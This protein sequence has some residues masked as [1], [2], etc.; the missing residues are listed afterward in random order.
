MNRIAMTTAASA[1]R[2]SR[3]YW[4]A[5]IGLASLVGAMAP[6]AHALEHFHV[7]L[8]KT[9]VIRCP[10]DAA[11]S[12]EL[13]GIAVTRPDRPGSARRA[14]VVND[15]EARQKGSSSVIEIDIGATLDI[16]VRGGLP[17]PGPVYPMKLEEMTL[18][19]DGR[20]AIATTAFDRHDADSPR[21]DGFNMLAGW[22]LMDGT[23]REFGIVM[24]DPGE[25]HKASVRR[26]LGATLDR[27]A[28][29]ALAY[30][31][32]EGLA[33]LPG[34]RLLFGIRAI[35]QDHQHATY[36]TILIE[37]RYLERNG[38]LLLDGTSP[39]HVV[40]DIGNALREA[41]NADIGLSGL[42]YHAAQNRLYMLTS[43][44]VQR[45]GKLALDAYLW[46]IGFDQ[47]G[48]LDPASL[49]L[50]NNRHNATFRFHHKAEGI[51]FLD[52]ETMVVVH[53]DDREPLP[54]DTTTEARPRRMNEAVVS[55]L[56]LTPP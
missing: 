31:K 11:Q 1:M 17:L 5:S 26:H 48:A 21:F 3:R 8:I 23:A 20:F 33:A 2:A 35:G 24:A 55:F 29:Q 9:S 47:A 53:D 38:A 18:T 54:I 16:K 22:D 44:E 14:F 28:G 46:T 49:A 12:C 25:N 27:H 56:R 36:S 6:Q 50:A 10:G 19:P 42:A 39:A 13:S 52:D 40:L 32:V 30:F 37:A 51:A 45:D 43:L 15:K 4:L 7:E 41:S 34:N